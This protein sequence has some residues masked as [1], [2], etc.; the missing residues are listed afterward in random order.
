M[1][2][3]PAD[4]PPSFRTK[5]EYN[6][7]NVNGTA[8]KMEPHI[9]VSY[10]WLI[11]PL[12]LYTTITIFLFIT[13]F[14]TRNAPPWKSSILALLRCMD[15]DNKLSTPQ[16]LNQYGKQTVVRLEQVRRGETWQLVDTTDAIDLPRDVK[17]K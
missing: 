11:M 5:P 16:Q 4:F 7:T 6:G 12:V 2:N 17:R 10:V 1:N 8:W 14:H 9:K 3:I 13:M 15:P